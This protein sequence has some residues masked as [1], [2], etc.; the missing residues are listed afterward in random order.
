MTRKSP[1]PYTWVTRTLHTGTGFCGY[2]YGLPWDTPGLPVIIPTSK[3][4][5]YHH[6][7]INDKS[8][9]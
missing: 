7:Y 3:H 5:I 4:K 2:G 9:W 1:Y 8:L 6:S